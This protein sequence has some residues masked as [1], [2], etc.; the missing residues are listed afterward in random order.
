MGA[1][2]GIG[3]V[4]A[5]SALEEPGLLH[6]PL[7]VLLTINEEAGMDGAR[8]LVSG[9]LQGKALINLDTEEWGH[10]TWAA[11]EGCWQFRR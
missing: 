7:E 5:L 11:Q 8:G 6:P 3:V 9:T 10:S 2:N 1:D 4:L